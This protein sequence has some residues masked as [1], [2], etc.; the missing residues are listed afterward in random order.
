MNTAAIVLFVL[1]LA[2]AGLAMWLLVYA[3]NRTRRDEITLRL[4]AGEQA[5]VAAKSTREA[6]LRNPLLRWACHFVWRAGSEA[7]PHTVA[8]MLWIL[9]A[10]IPVTLLIFGGFGGGIVIGFVLAFGYGVLRRQAARRR[11]KIVGQ[12]P[13]FLEAG[14]RV[15]Q[16]G[17]TL[18]E[19]LATAAAESPEP[20]RPLFQSVNRQV[21]LGAPLD[22]VLAESAAIHRIRDIKVIALAASINRKY[23]GSLRNV[24]RSLIA[25]IRSRDAAARELRALTAET[26]FSAVVLAVIP[27]F[28]TIYIY[29]QNR[30]YYAQ[31]WESTGGR[32][33]LIAGV[34]L[35]V[36]GVFVIYRMLAST[37]DTE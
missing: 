24:F 11:A 2:M 20:L 26:R 5:D 28:L 13:A 31:M 27:A 18:E 25:A 22:Q 10:M 1:A 32:I 36:L 21:R 7:E 33:T 12:L 17:N 29:L 9:G 35:Q 37:E 3:D 6:M 34:S 23:G 15:L 19:S 16:A 14:L 8:K 4:R 30:E